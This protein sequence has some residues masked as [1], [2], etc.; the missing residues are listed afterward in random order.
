MAL[1]WKKEYLRYKVL[2][3]NIQSTYQNHPDLKIYL[4]LLLS[5]IT[6]SFF[7]ILALKPTAL[8]I[9]DLLVKIKNRKETL[10]L[11]QNKIAT[12]QS[13]Q[14]N[15]NE[16]SAIL[17]LLEI[18]IPSN[19]KP[20]EFIRQIQGLAEKNSTNI[21]G[22]SIEESPLKGGAPKTSSPQTTSPFAEGASATNFSGTI[23]GSYAN[24]FSFLQ[25]LENLRMPIYISSFNLGTAKKTDNTEGEI[26]LSLTISGSVPFLKTDEKK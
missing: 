23:T 4:E 5:L 25:D 8:A 15:L 11:M 16:Q 9:S 21:S 6:I 19:P 14:K 10:A 22:F 2:F 12:L 7:G 26:K 3:L 20:E 24:L 13:A 17:P 18:A 1:G